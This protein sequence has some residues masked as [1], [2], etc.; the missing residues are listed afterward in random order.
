[1]ARRE[2]FDGAVGGAALAINSLDWDWKKHPVIRLDLNAGD[3]NR[4]IAE[5]DAMINVG[6]RASAEKYAVS[7]VGETNGE[8]LANMIRDLHRSCGER[9]VVIIDEYD[10][11]LLE[12]IDAPE[13]HREL[14]SA[15]KSFYGVLKPADEHL[16]F[17]FI[18]GV[19]KFAQVSI[20]SDLNHL[21]DLTLDPRYADLCGWTQEEV[22]ANFAPEIDLCAAEQDRAA[23]LARLKNF[24]NG[25]RFSK[26]ELT[27][28]NPFGLLLHFDSAGDF[29]SYWYNTGTPTFLLKLINEQKI[30]VLNLEHWRVDE[31]SFQKFDIANLNATVVLYQSGYLT[32]RDYEAERQSFVLDY[33]NEEVRASFAGALMEGV[34]RVGR[35]G[36]DALLTKLLDAI[37]DG[38]PAAAMELLPPFF[39]SIP[40]EII[41]KEERYYQTVVHLIFTMLGLNC[42]SEVH[43]AVGSVDTLVETRDFVYCFEFKLDGTVAEAL[44]QIDEKKYLLPYRG[45]GKKLFKIGAVFKQTERNLGA[46]QTVEA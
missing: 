35:E 19:T 24:Y 23:Y 33:P 14:R 5:L 8:R 25:Y 43:Q 34:L 13:K 9:V 2:L 31:R 11:P 4:S 16:R 32:I 44:A 39:A 41:V 38:K 28:Y 17:V 37:Y 40:H 10:K 29:A 46:W 21:K 3:Y 1:S 20:F 6:L 12:T 42:R 36:R 7:V 27:I 45:G 15:L 18:T 30:D 22:E 26:K